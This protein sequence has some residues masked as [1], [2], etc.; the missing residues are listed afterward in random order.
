M[1]RLIRYFRLRD[2]FGGLTTS[3]SFWPDSKPLPPLLFTLRLSTCFYGDEV[4]VFC[5]ETGSK[6]PS[7][8]NFRE[9]LQ[10]FR[11][12][13]PLF[14]CVQ[15]RHLVNMF[16]VFA[17]EWY[18]LLTWRLVVLFGYPS[19]SAGSGCRWFW[20]STSGFGYLCFPS[21][22]IN[23]RGIW[24]FA[25]GSPGS[26]KG[27]SPTS[28]NLWSSLCEKGMLPFFF[29]LVALPRFLVRGCT[30]LKIHSSYSFLAFDLLS[31]R[32]YG[33]ICREYIYI[34]IHYYDVFNRKPAS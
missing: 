16:L 21:A 5:L 2:L 22:D 8:I 20:S 3:H 32:F 26:V 1:S 19:N 31:R 13:P 34:Y 14:A 12:Q 33:I 11:R 7:N 23:V 15:A 9:R 4:P 24:V 28:L 6:T 30:P 17:N 25:F 18:L 10:F 27:R 29:E